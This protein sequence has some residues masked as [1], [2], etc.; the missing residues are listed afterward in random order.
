MRRVTLVSAALLGCL[1]FAS[2]CAVGRRTLPRNV[3]QT[4]G[5]GTA[6]GTGFIGEVADGRHFENKP[7]LPSVP[8]ID[9]DVTKA[10]KEQLAN[11]IGRQRN[12]Y[13]GALGDIGLPDHDTVMNRTRLLIEE[14]FRR[15]GYAI[16]TDPTS[17][18]TA[19]VVIDEFWAWITPGMWSLS[20]EANVACRI[21]LKKDGNAKTLNIRGYAINKGQA[22]TNPNW[23]KAYQ[24]AFAEFLARLDAE[25]TNAGL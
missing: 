16:G 14:G 10:S 15:K 12:T 17:A 18:T 25:L 2:G 7:Q 3:P 20:F 13:G 1:V 21:T 4:T 5:I 19:T 11:V 22:A 9:G 8:S 6:K 24:A 23:E